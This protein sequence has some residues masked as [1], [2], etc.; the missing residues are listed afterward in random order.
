MTTSDAVPGDQTR[1]LNVGSTDYAVKPVRR[2]ELLR[3][4]YKLF[5]ITESSNGE[6][7]N[8]SRPETKPQAAKFRILIVEDSEDNR[9]LLQ[10]YLKTGPFEI[11][12]AENGKLAVD[13]AKDTAFRSDPNGYAYASDERAYGDEA[14]SRGRSERMA[15]LVS[16]CWRYRPTRGAKTLI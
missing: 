12:F 14:D 9:F 1:V 4:I 10:E 6:G 2:P 11:K 3:L 7:R 8:S 5:S 16:L 13:L 15:T